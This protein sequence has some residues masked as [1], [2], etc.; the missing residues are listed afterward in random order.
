MQKDIEELKEHM[1][2]DWHDRRE[3]YESRVRKVLEQYPNCVQ[4]WLAIDGLR[5]VK[6]LGDYLQSVVG[7]DISHRTV[8]R[9]CKRLC[10]AGV[11]KK[12]GAKGKSPVYSKKGWTKE[13]NLDDYVRQTF[14]E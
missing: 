9:C 7:E 3:R 2:D 8:S 12:V 5:S 4:T 1:R 14:L 6:E 11:I 13:L 10:R